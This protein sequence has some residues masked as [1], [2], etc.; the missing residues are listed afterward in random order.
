[1]PGRRERTL[2]EQ[3]QPTLIRFMRFRDGVEY[4]KDHEFS[5]ATLSSVT[6]AEIVRW[7]CLKVYGTPDPT[8]EDNPT[9]GR[10]S[11]L[12][13]S[14]KALS[15]FMPNRLIHWNELANPP[16]GNPTKSSAVNDLIKRIKKKEVRK[17]GKASE[18]RKPFL[19][20]E[21]EQ[22]I[23]RMK[24]NENV[25]ARL[26][27]S[28]IFIFQLCMIAR[29]DDS[30]KLRHDD[31]KMNDQYPNF[32]ILAKLCWSKNVSE[33]RDAPDQI[34]IG[35]MNTCYCVILA[36]STWLEFW[37]ER[38]HI[39]RTE[40]AFGI[41][42]QQ[43][44]VIIKE[45]A[46]SYMREMFKDND[47]HFEGKRG[48]HSI[49]KL[50]TTRARKFGCSKDD[51]DTRGRWKRKRQQDCYA[52]T[53]LPYPDTKV[54]AAL[55]KGGLIHY[56]VK[57]NSGIAE[58]WILQHVDP[59]I[60]SRYCR[61]L[62]LVLGR[63]LLWRVFD[64]NESLVVPPHICHRV[65]SAY[66]DLGDRCQLVAGENP[67]ERDPLV[68]TGSDAEVHIDLLLDDDNN[69]VTGAAPR[70]IDSEQMMHMNSLMIG[71]RKDNAE[72]RAENSRN[73]E[74]QERN[75][76]VMNRNI[77][78]LMR[79]PVTR[80]QREQQQR[81]VEDALA[82]NDEEEQA[83]AAPAI[84]SRCP[85]TLHTL[86]IEFEFGLANRK[87]AK[88]FTPSERG[89]VKY[90]YHRRKVIWDKIGEM[91]RS[92]WSS[93]EACNKIYE[94]YGPQK[95]VTDIINLMRKD[96]KTGGHPSLRMVHV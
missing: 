20:R 63:A 43:D 59:Q 71:L 9:E 90:I 84:L 48:T 21:Y 30:A 8:P 87:A 50:A 39:E 46:S 73:A 41:F 42:G 78:H 74:R 75:V 19:E 25:E 22:V 26:F 49:R 1:M 45:Y 85:K 96:K 6:P 16:F 89:K 81:T 83:H 61:P 91:V 51:T 68:V 38:G 14:K 3:Y 47:F 23:T 31:I 11:S 67:V 72:L 92:G 80:L 4:D 10:S 7:M 27:L 62:A 54:A 94:A 52:D 12:A 13:F 93:D 58:D 66:Q 77:M 35:A 82:E 40:F 37:I 24:M 79:N 60:A 2:A 5:S 28:T 44:P 57:P 32:S 86:W 15:Y 70:R 34:L 17:Q 64:D 29:I 18:A 65:K 53:M 76:T 95:T 56:S 36:L 69:L 55:C 88:D 33:E